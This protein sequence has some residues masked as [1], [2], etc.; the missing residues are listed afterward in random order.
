MKT[1]VGI[2]IVELR[3]AHEISASTARTLEQDVTEEP[4][5]WTVFITCVH[6]LSF[7]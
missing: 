3:K 7:Q 6:V 2:M 4:G 1:N 5:Y